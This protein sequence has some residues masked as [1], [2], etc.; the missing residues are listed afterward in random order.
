MSEKRR[1]DI[2]GKAIVATMP[3]V[4]ECY[5]D[6]FN[7]YSFI[8]VKFR[9]GG[10][11]VRNCTGNSH[12]ANV[13]ELSEI[14][15]GGYYQEVEVYLKLKKQSTIWVVR[16]VDLLTIG[17]GDHLFA[18]LEEA[19]ELFHSLSA[20]NSYATILMRIDNVDLGRY[21]SPKEFIEN[22]ISLPQDIENEDYEIIQKK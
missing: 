19:E 13:K 3:D 18:S 15:G 17:Y 7:G 22:T 2:V 11:S 10:L 6:E 12:L 16:E 14:V 21:K 9:G 1:F 20:H 4:K 5:L 8:V